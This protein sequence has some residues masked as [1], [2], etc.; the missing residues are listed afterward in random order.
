MIE[1]RRISSDKTPAVTFNLCKKQENLCYCLPNY[2]ALEE[3][4]RTIK[5]TNSQN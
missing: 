1:A 5:P 3:M 4:R 2:K